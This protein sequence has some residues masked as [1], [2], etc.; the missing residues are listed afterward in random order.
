MPSD[1][2]SSLTGEVLITRDHLALYR[3]TLANERT[4]LA[5]VRTAL[6]FAGAGAGLLHFG[7]DRISEVSGWLCFPVGLLVLVYGVVSYRRM[8]RQIL[9]VAVEG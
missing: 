5:Y 7:G 2:I 3:T 4:L 6:A 9:A 8:H 1:P